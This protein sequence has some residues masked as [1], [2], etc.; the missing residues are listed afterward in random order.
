[1]PS[2]TDRLVTLVLKRTSA[3]EASVR[4]DI[5]RLKQYGIND[6]SILKTL[7]MKYGDSTGPS[8]LNVPA[9]TLIRAGLLI[10]NG[11]EDPR[12]L[13]E[14]DTDDIVDADVGSRSFAQAVIEGA[15][16]LLNESPTLETLREQT[17]LN[18]QSL[19]GELRP[20]MAAGIPPMR[21]STTSSRC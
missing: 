9:I 2:D 19:I 7:T 8:L 10:A 21:P 6:E 4:D 15:A 1:M 16:I 20:L 11:I 14:A 3:N 12:S 5:H 17:D 13:L 18:D